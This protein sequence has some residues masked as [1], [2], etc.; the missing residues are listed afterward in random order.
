M[1]AFRTTSRLATLGSIR[2]FQDTGRK[3]KSKDLWASSIGSTTSSLQHPGSLTAKIEILKAQRSGVL[4]AFVCFDS[5]MILMILGFR[6]GF[7]GLKV[8]GL[9][10][11]LTVCENWRQIQSM[12]TLAGWLAG[13]LRGWCPVGAKSLF[14]S[15]RSSKCGIFA[16]NWRCS[17][18]RWA[19]L[20]TLL[21]GM[22][23]GTGQGARID[24]RRLLSSPW[25]TWILWL[26]VTSSTMQFPYSLPFLQ[27]ALLPL[28]IVYPVTDTH[29]SRTSPVCPASSCHLE[30]TWI[31]ITARRY[32]PS[33]WAL[34]ASEPLQLLWTLTIVW[35][36]TGLHQS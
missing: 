6:V 14:F 22:S 19:F 1:I 26:Q 16:Q 2:E 28:E 3:T 31:L 7:Q 8:Q 35:C 5:I 20:S 11:P 34:Q 9:K 10:F 23:L 29:S 32:Q 21:A 27:M 18:P 4:L 12:Q 25:S 30:R 15:Y 24:F 36:W 17:R 33:A 13:K